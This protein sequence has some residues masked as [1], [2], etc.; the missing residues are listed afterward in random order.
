M[1]K[2]K[3]KGTVLQREISTVYTAVAQVVTVD[4]DEDKSQ[5]WDS[6]SL[7]SGVGGSRD[8]TGFSKPGSVSWEIWY[9]PALSGHQG[10][11]ALVTTPA[12]QAW[13]IV[14]ADG[15]SKT[16]SFT[17]ADFGMGF[18]VAMNDGLK[19][20]CSAELDGLPTYPS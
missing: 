2:V 1:A 18:S 15:A 19:A 13:K 10:L 7:D 20:K 5:G 8:M 11:Y 3:C 4:K 12:K 14:F 9:D 16:M 17:T 6:T